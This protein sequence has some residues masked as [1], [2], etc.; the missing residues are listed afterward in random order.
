MID[1]F[2]GCGGV[3]QG[4]KNQ[5]FQ[6]L[7]AVELDPITMQTYRTNHPE[8]K[9]Y[10]TDIQKISPQQMMIDCGLTR[11]ELTVLSVCAPCQPYS[12]LNRSQQKD[13]RTSLVLQMARFVKVLQPQFV[14]MENIPDL[15]RGTNQKILQKL[16]RSLRE[17]L[18]YQMLPPQIVDAVN[19]GVPQFRRRLILLGSRDQ[20][21]PLGI[22][23]AT[24]SDPQE[25]QQT[26]KQPWRTIRKAFGELVSFKL[27]T[28]KQSKHD[29]LHR[30]PKH[31]PLVIAR[32][33]QIPPNGGSRSSL[34][35]H[36]RL[37]CHRRQVGHADVYGRMD[38]EKPSNTIR[39]GFSPSKG[40]FIHPTANRG[41]TPME[42]ARIQTF[43]DSYQFAGTYSE[44]CTQIGNAVPVRLAEVFADYFYKLWLQQIK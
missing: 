25:I 40:R 21:L 19:Y 6:V 14:L 32:L 9:S 2:A 20:K 36:L 37:K 1:L 42:A 33:K 11:G 41:I 31:S 12:S 24:H 43:P 8:V 16:V 17:E 18:R 27:A 39:T 10:E 28:G 22:P 15:N 23:E 26:G 34:P 30:A 7:A 13:D 35:E 5:G 38:F 4:F 44:I 3:T 29:P